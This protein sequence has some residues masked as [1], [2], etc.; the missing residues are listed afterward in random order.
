MIQFDPDKNALI[1]PSSFGIDNFPAKALIIYDDDYFDK[2]ATENKLS[3]VVDSSGAKKDDFYIL[4][5]KYLIMYPAQGA[6]TSAMMLEMAIASG[7][8]SVVAF[9]TAGSLDGSTL[10]HNIIIPTAAIREEGVSYHYLPDSEEVAQ[11][12]AS[13]EILKKEI[14]KHDLE[15]MLGKTWT[16]DAFFRETADKAKTMK[17]KGCV[18][19]DMECAA[20]IAVCQFRKIDFAQ[21]LISFDNLEADHNHR[22]VYGDLMSDAILKIAFGVLDKIGP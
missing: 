12:E 9:G 3:E 11:D 17:A 1:N 19:V 14:Q 6:P 16:T 2:L 13:I 4:G 5:N 8:K 10:P 7:V 15:F 22:D 21:F 18:C 20:L